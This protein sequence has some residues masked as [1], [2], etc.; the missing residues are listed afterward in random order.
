MNDI[1]AEM[2]ATATSQSKFLFYLNFL[3]HV[4]PLFFFLMFLM[5]VCG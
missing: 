3:G 5:L 2:G 1:T 4:I